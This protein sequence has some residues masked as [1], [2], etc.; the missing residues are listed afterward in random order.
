M[1]HKCAMHYGYECWDDADFCKQVMRFYPETRVIT[2]SE[3]ASIIVPD[4]G[5]ALEAKPKRYS[6]TFNTEAP[7][8]EVA[9]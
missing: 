4:F 9:A 3:K 5:T 2:K 8:Q 6:K 7:A 1:Y